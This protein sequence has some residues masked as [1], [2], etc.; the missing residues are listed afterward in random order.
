VE[1]DQE[2]KFVAVN[3]DEKGGGDLKFA[4]TWELRKVV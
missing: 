4:L 2:K 1:P 3:I